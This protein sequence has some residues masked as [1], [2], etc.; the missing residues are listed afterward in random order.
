MVAE[1]S[2]W[3]R[4]SFKNRELLNTATSCGCYYC[5]KIYTPTEIKEW[6]D[7]NQTAICPYC[8][9]DAVLDNPTLDLLE[10]G[11]QIGFLQGFEQGNYT[12]L[13]KFKDHRNKKFNE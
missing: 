5:G 1:M 2:E 3:G 13:I 6:T 12:K 11:H 8:G 4:R 10:E 7:N 9:I